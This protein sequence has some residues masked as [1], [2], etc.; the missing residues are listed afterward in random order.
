M[1]L[2]RL[3]VLAL[4]LVLLT[5]CASPPAFYE[6][7]LVAS[8][9][10]AENAGTRVTVSFEVWDAKGRPV[11]DV[12]ASD[13]GIFEDGVRASSESTVRLQQTRH[14]IDIV[15]LLDR[16]SSIRDEQTGSNVRTTAEALVEG[17]AQHPCNVHLYS[18]A[19]TVEPI[20]SLDELT[21]SAAV[22]TQSRWT[23]LYYAIHTVLTERNLLSRTTARR[24]A[25]QAPE[26]PTTVVIVCTDGADNY[27]HNHELTTLTDLEKQITTN[28]VVIH[29]L[30]LGSVAEEQDRTGVTGDE[31]LRRLA[32]H[33]TYQDAS[34][35]NAADIVIERVA[36]H[37]RS[38]YSC[39]FVSPSI[40]GEHELVLEVKRDG[41]AG[42]STPIRFPTHGPRPATPEPQ[43]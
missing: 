38:T 7:R 24:H 39:V 4:P 15:L 35:E 33:G 37:V 21:S 20:A 12:T 43:R 25:N 1:R 32:V 3:L 41:T 23:A 31:A 17:L 42:R 34:A 13:L 29:A 18:F 10:D 28:R 9:Y 36:R 8:E 6:S 40:T 30:G 27:S 5:S 2:T 16:S 11:G 22:G 14:P 26:S 19:N